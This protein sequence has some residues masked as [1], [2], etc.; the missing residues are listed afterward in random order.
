M[1]EGSESSAIPRIR[2]RI[3][4]LSD[5]V[6]GLAL[7]FGSLIL[8]GSQP[9]NGTDLVVNVFIFGFSFMIIIWTWIGYTR[10]FA[11]LP[12]EAP[13][14]LPL[15]L[16]LLFCVALEPYLFYVVITTKTLELVDPASIA[17][18]IDA[19][20]MFLF[21]AGLGYIVVKEEERRGDDKRLHPIVVNRFRRLTR[22][23]AIVG[24]I[25]IASALP[26]FWVYTPVGILRFLLWSSP[27]IILTIFRKP[28]PEAKPITQ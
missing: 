15:N 18:A 7:S 6:F 28:K 1:I 5:L 10:T 23:Q 25:Y 21:L 2:V 14:A 26:I 17:Y 22:L 16:G 12:T 11:V 13:F 20:L 3:E 27:F 4:S 9:R 24:G 8:I 19:G